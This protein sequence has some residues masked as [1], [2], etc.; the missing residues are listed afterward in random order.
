MTVRRRAQIKDLDR[1]KVQFVIESSIIDEILLTPKPGLV[2]D[3]KDKDGPEKEI[4][5]DSART[6]SPYLTEMFFIGYNWKEEPEGLYDKILPIGREAE[7]AMYETTDGFNTHKGMIFTMGIISAAAGYDLASRGENHITSILTISESIMKEPMRRHYEG[8]KDHRPTTQGERLYGLYGFKGIRGEAEE[9]FPIIRKVSYP[10]MREYRRRF[11]DPEQNSAILSNVLLQIM[12]ALQDTC[13]ISTSDPGGLRWVQNRARYILALGGA[14]TREWMDEL[15][16][17]REDC[18][19]I[20]I[21]PG[22]SGDILAATLFLWR[23]SGRR[24]EI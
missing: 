21:S 19:R 7:S 6:I 14:F 20:K 10:A 1:K 18:S 2:D 13:I 16:D 22:G 17:M 24:F 23:I 12:T 15:W 11:P 3:Y 9:G 5:L 4:F 8:V